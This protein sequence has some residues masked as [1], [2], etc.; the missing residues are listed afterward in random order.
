MVDYTW[1]ESQSTLCSPVV[2]D[3]WIIENDLAVVHLDSIIKNLFALYTGL[4]SNHLIFWYTFII[5]EKVTLSM[6]HNVHVYVQVTNTFSAHPGPF[7]TLVYDINSYN[8]N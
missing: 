4:S 7:Y 6:Y 1:K 2:S 5:G 8:V 3:I